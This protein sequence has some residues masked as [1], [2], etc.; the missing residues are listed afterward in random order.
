MSTA[1]KPSASPT[2]VRTQD[3][4]P[5]AKT[6]PLLRKRGPAGRFL[7]VTACILTCH[8][9]S[10]HSSGY[11]HIADRVGTSG[12]YNRSLC[13][14]APVLSSY[15]GAGTARLTHVPDIPAGRFPFFAVLLALGGGLALFVPAAGAGCRIGTI[16]IASRLLLR[17]W[18]STRRCHWD[19]RPAQPRCG[20]VGVVPQGFPMSPV[21]DWI[22]QSRCAGSRTGHRLCCAEDRRAWPGGRCAFGCQDLRP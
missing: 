5:P 11:G 1:V 9:G 8:C 10:M 15:P 6:V 13:R 17:R 19:R 20:S 7:L 4:P 18:P 21:R 2:L 16:P 14:S 3:L 22:R 12:A